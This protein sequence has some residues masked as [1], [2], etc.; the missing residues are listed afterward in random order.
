M[1]PA[2]ESGRDGDHLY[3]RE[4]ATRCA[5]SS[6]AGA[7]APR[8]R[9]DEFALHYQPIVDLD[10]RRIVGV[11]ALIRWNDAD[12]GLIMPGEFI[13][14]AERTGLIEPI[15]D[16]VVEEACRQARA[17]ARRGPRP[18]RVG[19][20]AAAAFWQPTAMRDVLDDDRRRSASRPTA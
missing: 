16:W 18:V 10:E 1:Y 11:E 17:L 13:P 7:A 6:L 3:T 14:L 20:P 19:Q 4:A 5:R 12:R 2:K 15:S 8:G 9:R